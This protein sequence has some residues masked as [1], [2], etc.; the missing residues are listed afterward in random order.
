MERIN[1]FPGHMHKARKEIAQLMDEVDIVIEVL[2]A[3]LPRSSENPLVTSLRR[4]KPVLK[5]LNKSDLAD[6]DKTKAWLQEFNAQEG[7]TAI[8]LTTSDK[9]TIKSIPQICKDAV[10]ARANKDRPVRAMIMGIPNVGKSTLINALLGRRIA[11]VGNEPAVTKA[12]KRY[13][14]FQGMALS[15]TPGILW[16]K[17]EDQDSGYRLAVS[18]AIKDTAIDYDQVAVY[19][20]NFI[21]NAYP[22]RLVERYKLKELPELGEGL[23]DQI[24]RKRG[25]LRPGGVVDIHK[26]A[27]ILMNEMRG[28]KLGRISFETVEEWQEKDRIAAELAAQEAEEAA[29]AEESSK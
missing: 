5:I 27:E 9:R 4:G 25:C 28:G 12:N 19:G 11:K 15:D 21:L 1:W 24:G 10:P 6:P 2:D 7:I 20:A 17:I 26:A 3:R 23:L 18:G 22:E 29:K 16:P 14:V 13:S 8:E